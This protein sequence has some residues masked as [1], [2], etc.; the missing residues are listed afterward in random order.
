MSEYMSCKEGNIIAV[1]RNRL[2][3]LV[4]KYKH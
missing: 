2:R 1:L 4:K 3:T